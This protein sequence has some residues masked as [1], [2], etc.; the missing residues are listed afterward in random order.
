MGLTAITYSAPLS[1]RAAAITGAD[2][3]AGASG[4]TSAAARAV[5]SLDTAEM[6]GVTSAGQ[7]AGKN[8]SPRAPP[9]TAS[10]LSARTVAGVTL[11]AGALHFQVEAS[12]HW[13]VGRPAASRTSSRCD[14]A[15]SGSQP[16]SAGLLERVEVEAD[17]VRPGDQPR[18]DAAPLGQR[19]R[20]RVEVVAEREDA[21][22]PGRRLRRKLRQRRARHPLQVGLV[23]VVPADHAG[24]ADPGLVGCGQRQC[25]PV[26]R[27]GLVGDP[28][29]RVLGVERDAGRQAALVA[30]RA[31]REHEQREERLAVEQDRAAA[32][33]RDG[34]GRRRR[35]GQVERRRRPPR[36]GTSCRTSA[37]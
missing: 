24:P 13:N 27:R 15:T 2:A 12:I 36:P 22:P 30:G 17:D 8:P 33:G 25:A 11:S 31:L 32:R 18:I 34:R 10:Q 29:A 7:S 6:P 1:A 28:P 5:T 21:E 23:G 37:R 26:Q 4:A 9:A 20:P 14:A 3:E 35:R 19:R 16:T